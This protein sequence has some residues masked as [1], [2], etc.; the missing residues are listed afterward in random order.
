MQIIENAVYM[1]AAKPG[2]GGA[3]VIDTLNVTP[4][5]SAQTI[6]APS[7]TDGYSPVNVS[8]VDSSIDAN[9]VAGNIKSGVSI[10]GVSGNV[11]ELNGTT[12]SVTPTTS[13]QTITPTAPS[14]GFTEVSV[15][16]VTSAIDANITAGNIKKDVQILGVTGSYEGQTPTGTMYI[17][18][19][20]TY[21]VADK[22]I[23]DVQVPT[24]APAHYIEKTVDANGVLQNSNTF[25]NLNNVTDIGGNVLAYS[26]Y[27]NTVITGVL[28]LSS[29]PKISGVKALNYAFANCTGITSVDMS[30]V[31]EISGNNSCESMFYGCTG[32]TYADLSSLTKVFSNSSSCSYMFHGC[33]H[34]TSVN[35]SSL[36]YVYGSTNHCKRMF[37][38]CSALTNINLSSLLDIGSSY[39]CQEIFSGCTGLTSVDM[40]SLTRVFASGL[41]GAFNNC[42]SLT[43]ID[44][45]SLKDINGNSCLTNMCEKCTSLTSLS[46]PAFTVATFGTKTNQFGSIVKN[47]TGC[48]I[49]FPKNLD[50]QT[51]VTVVSRLNGYPNFDGTNTVI[52]F[53]L[54]STAHLIGNDTVEYERSPKFDTIT[55]LA[56]RVKDSAVDSTT[57]YTSGT[58]DPVVGNTIYSDSACTT[59]VT[60]ISSIA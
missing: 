3:P 45:S 51:G 54:P 22:A 5:T 58:A 49:H 26:Y 30:S 46:F 31:V 47:V 10:L 2:Q 29:L 53:D 28:D 55:A 14:N 33:T 40:S 19:N 15:S 35:L 36:S 17:I 6:T 21:N 50:P 9:I 39:G 18:S 43:N 52:S 37:M 57:Y 23:A 12:A 48:T 11:V 41:S 38:Q 20:G 13:A 44:L 42:T 4:T 8:A 24:T 34:L 56:W 25:I 27:G 59:S 32:L 16:A 60:T 1:G 7:G